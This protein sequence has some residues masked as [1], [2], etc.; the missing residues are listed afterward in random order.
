MDTYEEC[1]VGVP[2]D[3]DE[4]EN[5]LCALKGRASRA[6]SRLWDEARWPGPER[7]YSL[8]QEL[9]T[10]RGALEERIDDMPPHEAR[11]WLMANVGALQSILARTESERWHALR[12]LVWM[13]GGLA[14]TA[15]FL[16]EASATATG[17]PTA[18][19]W[20]E[21]EKLV[22]EAHA[23]HAPHAAHAD[24][25]PHADD[26]DDDGEGPAPSEGDEWDD[27]NSL[28]SLKERMR[29]AVY[30]LSE[31]AWGEGNAPNHSLEYELQIFLGEVK[32]CLDAMS[33]H[34]AHAWLVGNIGAIEAL[35]ARTERERQHALRALVGLRGSASNISD[36]LEEISAPANA[37]TPTGAPTDDDDEGGDDDE[38][39]E[40][41]DDDEGDFHAPAVRE[42][43]QAYRTTAMKQRD[44]LLARLR[45][46][47]ARLGAE[48]ACFASWGTNEQPLNARLGQFQARAIFCLKGICPIDAQAW[49]EGN[50]G[51]LEG[52]HAR[53]RQEYD[54][55]GLVLSGV[56]DRLFGLLYDLARER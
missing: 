23:A 39:E 7:N 44:L 16:A 34:E 43:V 22:A 20:D 17:A 14:L 24:D 37:P 31:E 19:S 36:L 26:D 47:C 9:K 51:E 21:A 54:Q 30:W 52:L 45:Q 28:C 10:F 50:V 55:A 49:L 40:D 3:E 1:G 25:A 5:S 13:R 38:D 35:R 8:E 46:A 53:N 27:E 18:P 42:I 29:R 15:D 41:D 4:D 12:V 32:G 33:P 56:E 2:W 6:V 11:K 48:A